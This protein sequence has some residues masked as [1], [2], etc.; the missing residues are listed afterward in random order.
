MTL[1]IERHGWLLRYVPLFLW[2]GVI[3]YL[4]S[5]Q[6]SASETSRFIR[7]ILEFFFPAALP[8][9][10]SFYHGIIRKFA[11]FAAYALLGLL[12]C[13]AFNLAAFRNRRLLY[14][15]LL[16]IVVA[17]LDETNQSF[18]PGRTGSAIDVTIDVI[19]G[20]VAVVLYYLVG[21]KN[22]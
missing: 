4:S 18:N 12:A 16:V 19:G 1:S 13:R 17:V 7:P 2:I 6:G 3:F 21:K 14:A 10:I 8:E 22:S 11:H 5:S 15:W 20:T 9:T